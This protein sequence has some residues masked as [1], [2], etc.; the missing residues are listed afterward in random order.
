MR[1]K[2]SFAIII[3]LIVIGITLVIIFNQNKNKFNYNF[4]FTN[5]EELIAV[6]YLNNEKE[7][8]QYFNNLSDD[9]ITTYTTDGE[10]LYLIIPRSND[11]SITIYEANLE[12]NGNLAKGE[13]IA[14]TNEPFIIKCNQS[15]IIPN[16]ILNITSNDLTIEYSPSL[17]L[18][19]GSINKN[20]NKN[21]L[22]LN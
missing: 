18:K 14:K 17:S 19:D 11:I 15:D 2:I 13:I 9:Q 16:T 1:K 3:L 20:K 7:A 4:S 12:E 5:D 22:T 10:E 8:S 6:A 21:I